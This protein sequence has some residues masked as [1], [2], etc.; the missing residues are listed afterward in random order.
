MPRNLPSASDSTGTDRR[1]EGS[2][3]S[4]DRRLQHRNHGPR[5][6]RTG[7]PSAHGPDCLRVGCSMSTALTVY[8]EAERNLP[9]R[10]RIAVPPDGFGSQLDQMVAWLDA[11]CGA[12]SWAMTPSG[13][14]GLLNDSLAIYFLN[15]VLARAFVN[16]WCIGCQ[17]EVGLRVRPASRF[18][19]I[20]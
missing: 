17:I 19:A 14:C 8:R 11:N 16:R 5:P 9:V 2:S 15:P 6:P 1:A 10:I 18:P 13:T 7:A 20:D 4:V 12:E 3:P